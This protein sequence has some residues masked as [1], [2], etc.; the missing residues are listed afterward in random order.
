MVE[1][2]DKKEKIMNCPLCKSKMI[3]GT[4]VLTFKMDGTQILVIKDVPALICDQ[5]GEE[6]VNIETS[7]NV[8]KQVNQAVADGINMGFL[9]YNIAA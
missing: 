3:E 2:N 7:K 8:E 5:C 1:P 9:S 6:Y 4:T